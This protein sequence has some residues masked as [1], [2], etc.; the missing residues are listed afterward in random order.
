[1]IKKPMMAT[2]EGVIG[3]EDEYSGEETPN[4]AA[5]MTYRKET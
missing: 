4:S 5:K 2:V 1:V 3:F